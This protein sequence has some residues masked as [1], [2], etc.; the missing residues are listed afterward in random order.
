[1]ASPKLLERMSAL[2]QTCDRVIAIRDFH[3][4]EIFRIKEELLNP[5]LN[6]DYKKL[7]SDEITYNIESLEYYNKWVHFIIKERAAVGH[8]IMI[9]PENIKNEPKMISEINLLI[10]KIQKYHD[11]RS[12]LN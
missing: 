1:M 7:F 5:D 8:L 11:E 10:G 6:E 3:E 9:T 4:Q 12:K 2:F